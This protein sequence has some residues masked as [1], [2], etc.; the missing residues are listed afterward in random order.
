M[1]GE[2]FDPVEPQHTSQYRHELHLGEFLP[3][4]V[5][6]AERP[7]E[8]RF[9][10]RW[11]LRK[12]FA[13]ALGITTIW[14]RDPPGRP[15]FF[16]VGPPVLGHDVHGDGRREHLAA[17]WHKDG[18]AF[19]GDLGAFAQDVFLVVGNSGKQAQHLVLEYQQTISLVDCDIR[20][21]LLW[22]YTPM[23]AA[24]GKTYK[25]SSAPL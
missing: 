14:D 9:L 8:E 25:H 19:D 4:A 3:W 16:A 5:A 11:G 20:G 21:I 15:E 13:L 1:D 18:A 7:W 10:G 2:T 24:T 12:L 6:L 23:P 17:G 22:L